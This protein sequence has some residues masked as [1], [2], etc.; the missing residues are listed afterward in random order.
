MRVVNH[1]LGVY[2][3]LMP[4]Q[5]TMAIA[6]FADPNAV[7]PLATTGVSGVAYVTVALAIVLALV[8]GAAWAL[9]R[10]R[11]LQRGAQSAL[12]VVEAISVGTKERAVLIRVNDR[13]VLLGVAAGQVNLLLDLGQVVL[14]NTASN[15]VMD[16]SQS[17]T[18]SGATAT[19]P[20][21]KA[22]LKRSMGLS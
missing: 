6:A 1:F 8:Y 20:S 9:R 7:K 12:A 22:L 16:V 18:N 15:P 17:A 11:S 19:A 21:F 5:P 14:A 10:L 13:H 2:C 4:L 3:V